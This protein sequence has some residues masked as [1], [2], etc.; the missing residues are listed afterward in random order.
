MNY[1]PF[2]SCAPRVNPT[3][4]LKNPL[5]AALPTGLMLSA[6]HQAGP[7]FTG[8]RGRPIGSGVVMWRSNPRE[9]RDAFRALLDAERAALRTRPYPELEVLGERPS[10]EVRVEGRPGSIGTIVRRQADGSLRVVVQGIL[11]W[12]G[13]LARLLGSSD[14]SV[15]GFCMRPDGSVRELDREELREFD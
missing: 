1:A 14:V 2:H 9:T 7:R 12:Q 13:L 15:D 8:G 10:R 6:G 4:L 3:G 11:P 5:V